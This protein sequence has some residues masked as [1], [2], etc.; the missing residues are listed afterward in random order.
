M[1]S[2]TSCL[3][4][5]PKTDAFDWIYACTTSTEHTTERVVDT[6]SDNDFSMSSSKGTKTDNTDIYTS[7][8]PLSTDAI[9]LT[10]NSKVSD[11]S[12]TTTPSSTSSFSTTFE[13]TSS[14]QETSPQSPS[15]PSV[16]LIS[17]DQTYSGT[18]FSTTNPAVQSS[19]SNTKEIPKE[20]HQTDSEIEKSSPELHTTLAT[21][22]L[23]HEKN[24]KSSK[25]L[26]NLELVGV[27][28][29]CLVALI[30]VCIVGVL[31]Q[32][33]RT[34]RD[35]DSS[36]KFNMEEINIYLDRKPVQKESLDPKSRLFSSP[37]DIYMRPPTATSIRKGP[38]MGDVYK[39]QHLDTSFSEKGN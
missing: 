15:S 13:L 29:G 16:T 32:R 35:A 33:K 28:V 26:T 23:N 9:T 37:D 7:T 24:N 22:Q 14:G 10:K 38:D 1:K 8:M 3:R 25:K 21:N 12:E 6:S 36:S 30:L 27:G 39:L 2:N 20:T 18:P 4:C 5:D 19:P 11:A 17:K 34:N 31:L